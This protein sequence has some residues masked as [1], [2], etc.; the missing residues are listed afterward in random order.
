[1]QGFMFR[2]GDARFSAKI[3]QDALRAALE[4]SS[5]MIVNRNAGSGTRILI[6]QLL[7]GRRQPG[8]ANQPKSHNAVAGRNRT[9]P[10]RL[11]DCHCQ[12]GEALWL[13]LSTDCTGAL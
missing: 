12:R 5:C 8:Y 4:D 7:K 9:R 1:M 2:P 6:D 11:G 3:A 10:R 13:G